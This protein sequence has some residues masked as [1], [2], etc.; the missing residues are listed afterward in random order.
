[1]MLW[2]KIGFAL[3]LGGVVALGT[4]ELA[5]MVVRAVVL[6]LAGMVAS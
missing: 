4:A 5:G 2:F 1:M 6:W 3:T